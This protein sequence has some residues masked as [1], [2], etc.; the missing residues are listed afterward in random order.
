MEKKGQY[1]EL[2]NMQAEGY[3]DKTETTTPVEAEAKSVEEGKAEPNEEGAVA[4]EASA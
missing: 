3:L 4:A 2:F 1:Y